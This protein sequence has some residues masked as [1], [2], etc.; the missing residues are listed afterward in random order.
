MEEERQGRTVPSG[1]ALQPAPH[2]LFSPSVRAAAA[3]F[4]RLALGTRLVRGRQL[5]PSIQSGLG[6][7]VDHELHT[8]SG[9][10]LSTQCEQ[11]PP[12]W[13]LAGI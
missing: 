2:T 11:V 6:T 10:D 4:G 1:S 7:F 12:P 5:C 13:E 8:G 3:I 9:R